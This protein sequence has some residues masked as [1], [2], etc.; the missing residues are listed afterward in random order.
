MKSEVQYGNLGDVVILMRKKLKIK[1][2]KGIYSML[3]QFK[4]LNAEKISLEMF[5]NE[6]KL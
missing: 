5:S 1:G 2:P 6:M 4:K 3:M